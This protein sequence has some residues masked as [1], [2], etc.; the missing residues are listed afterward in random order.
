ME[1]REKER[2]RVLVWNGAIYGDSCNSADEIDK[3]GPIHILINVF[4]TIYVYIE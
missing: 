2:W 1:K 3:T 4:I